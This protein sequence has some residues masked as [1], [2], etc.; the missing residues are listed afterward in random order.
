MV[1]M[2]K[3]NADNYP[4]RDKQFLIK[5]LSNLY[6]VAMTKFYKEYE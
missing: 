4:T 6:F 5:K 1:S 3:K 2:D